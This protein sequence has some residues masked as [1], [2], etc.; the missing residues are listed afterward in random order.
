MRNPS[1]ENVQTRQEAK[2]LSKQHFWKLVGMIALI[3]VTGMATSMVSALF[4]SPLFMGSSGTDGSGTIATL[5]AV[6]GSIAIP[7]ICGLVSCG[8]TLGLTAAMLYIAKGGEYVSVGMVFSR[9]S[10]CLKAFGLSLWV[11]L[12]TL[13]WTLPGFALLIGGLLFLYSF[14]NAADTP[15]DGE[16]ILIF[17]PIILGY[18]LIFTLMI[19]AS[20]R[21]MLSTYVLANEADR[22][23]RACVTLSKQM[24]KGHKWQAF[25][26]VVPYILIL[27]AVMFGAMFLISLLVS[28]LPTNEFVQLLVTVLPMVLM[29]GCSLYLGIRMGLSYCIFYLKRRSELSAE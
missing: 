18:V 22:G 10:Q 3:F 4:L 1:N 12:K 21:Y 19:S 24:M 8:L 13:L 16:L 26:L 6:L 29:I 14:Q 27:Y 15:S 5:L 11:G 23:I 25:K 7:L 20:F 28:A 9:M 2:A 17:L